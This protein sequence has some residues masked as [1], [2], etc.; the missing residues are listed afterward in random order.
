[1]AATRG[2]DAAGVTQLPAPPEVGKKRLSRGNKADQI[3]LGSSGRDADIGDTGSRQR[4]RDLSRQTKVRGFFE[5]AFL[6]SGALR[7]H[8]EGGRAAA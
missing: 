6:Q 4:F 1:M 5:R 2:T 8:N 7:C 3:C